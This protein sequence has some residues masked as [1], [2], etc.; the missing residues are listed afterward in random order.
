MPLLLLVLHTSIAVLPRVRKILARSA[1]A[2]ANPADPTETGLPTTPGHL[3]PAPAVPCARLIGKA[4]WRARLRLH[5]ARLEAL[6]RQAA[7]R[8]DDLDD[9]L[10]RCHPVRD[11]ALF[12]EAARL[13][14]ELERVQTSSSAVRRKR[15]RSWLSVETT[16]APQS[17]SRDRAPGG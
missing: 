14:R 6:V 3:D 12:S 8:L 17:C 1:E 11:A 13:H 10:L 2:S 5:D 7:E 4:R 16:A 9:R 15:R